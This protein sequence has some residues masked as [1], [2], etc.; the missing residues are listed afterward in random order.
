MAQ[1]CCTSL[2]QRTF[3]T[4]NNHLRNL[5]EENQQATSKKVWSQID[6]DSVTSLLLTSDFWLVKPESRL[7]T[8]LIRQDRNSDWQWQF[9]YLSS[10]IN[11]SII[12]SSLNQINGN[13]GSLTPTSPALARSYWSME[14]ASPP[15]H[16]SR[17]HDVWSIVRLDLTR[18]NCSAVCSLH[19]G[20]C[21][22]WSGLWYLYFHFVL[23]GLWGKKLQY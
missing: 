19:L 5:N 13:Q 21:Q 22:S 7:G 12:H 18:V 10:M 1:L 20:N 3:S 4:N 11:Q 23:F 14:V 8:G 16:W 9:I 2:D 6:T 15:M 17:I